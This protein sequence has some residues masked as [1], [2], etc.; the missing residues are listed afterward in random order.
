MREKSK[1][2]EGDLDLSELWKHWWRIRKTLWRKTAEQSK[3]TQT[4]AAKCLLAFYHLLLLVHDG[5]YVLQEILCITDTMNSWKR[6]DALWLRLHLT[7]MLGSRQAV[8]DMQMLILLLRAVHF[9]RN[10]TT[11]SRMRQWR[12]CLKN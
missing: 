12:F 9:L 1:Q 5:L 2:L 4:T 7:S 10:A 8:G 3:P 6:R 11:D